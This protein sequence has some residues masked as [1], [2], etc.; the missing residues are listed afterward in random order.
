GPS[1][2]PWCLPARRSSDLGDGICDE[3]EE[4]CYVPLDRNS[5][6][7][8]RYARGSDRDWEPIR[9]Q[10]PE[11]VCAKLEQDEIEAVRATLACDTKTD[12]KSTRLNSSHVK[13][14]Y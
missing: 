8:W 4:R 5:L 3:V 14:S 6:F 10:L 11:A 13:I 12:R 7:G 2:W 9:A 1:R